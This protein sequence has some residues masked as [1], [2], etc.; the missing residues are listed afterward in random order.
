MSI[1]NDFPVD[2]VA[3]F[4]YDRGHHRRIYVRKAGG[5]ISL[6][7]S[8][9][10]NDNIEWIKSVKIHMEGEMRKIISATPPDMIIDHGKIGYD[11]EQMIEGIVA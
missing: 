11:I 6:E 10:V 9:T 7:L 3:E 1:L 4:I 2:H 5:W 8:F